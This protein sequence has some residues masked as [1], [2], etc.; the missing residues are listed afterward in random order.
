MQAQPTPVNIISLR[1]SHIF[2]EVGYFGMN[3]REMNGNEKGNMSALEEKVDT[4]MRYCIAQSEQARRHCHVDL[5]AMLGSQQENTVETAIDQALADLGVP[6]H[7]LGYR[8]L[9]CAIRMV[10]AEPD[11]VYC[12][13]TL[14][15]PGV[16]RRYGTTAALVERAIR[17]AVECGW[18]RCDG[19]MREHYFGGKIKPGRLRPTNAEYIARLANIVRR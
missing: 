3:L 18:N 4:L 19:A 11:A 15:Y 1:N 8:Y 7:L 14:L 2:K 12:V 16:A 17:H 10:V 5:R 13:T 6:D 9:Q